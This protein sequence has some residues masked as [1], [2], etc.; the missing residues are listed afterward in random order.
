MAPAPRTPSKPSDQDGDPQTK[1]GVT[2]SDRATVLSELL[3]RSQV[4]GWCWQGKR[5]QDTSVALTICFSLLRG[6]C[7]PC[8]E[9]EKRPT[10]SL[11]ILLPL[12]PEE[13]GLRRQAAL[14]QK[15]ET[16][17]GQSSEV[18]LVRGLANPVPFLLSLPSI[19]PG[20]KADSDYVPSSRA[21]SSRTKSCP[22]AGAPG[23]E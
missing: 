22:K 13:W 21:V 9:D 7:C 6:H 14:R 5:K 16:L 18:S 3:S 17:S 4:G 12:A 2:D 20:T 1:M 19:Y 23:L 8:L 15:Y 10:F 11:V